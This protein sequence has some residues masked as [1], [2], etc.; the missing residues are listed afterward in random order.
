MVRHILYHYYLELNLRN[1]LQL[2]H[3]SVTVDVQYK[4]NHIYIIDLYIAA[5]YGLAYIKYNKT[6]QGNKNMH[7]FLLE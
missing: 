1:T 7:I 3:V 2:K 4:I 6:S 5:N